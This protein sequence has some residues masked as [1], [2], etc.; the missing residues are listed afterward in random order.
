MI[1]SSV[2]TSFSDLLQSSELDS[3]A[4]FFSL[5]FFRVRLAIYDRLSEPLLRI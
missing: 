2:G 5:L 4:A 1:S 3:A